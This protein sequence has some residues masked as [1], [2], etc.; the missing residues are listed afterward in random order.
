MAKETFE[1]SYPGKT[2]Q[3]IFEAARKTID[4]V[5]TRHSLDHHV[6]AAKLEGKVARVGAKGSY[7]VAGEKLTLD[8]EFGMLVPGAIR[9]R[10][11]EE[12]AGS[13]DKLFA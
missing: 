8:L 10:V 3:Q 11:A 7:R 1:R 6:D 9:K 13:L 2:P 4:E 12:V 5:A